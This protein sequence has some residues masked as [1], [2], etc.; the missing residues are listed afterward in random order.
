M[1]AK[2]TDP[3][4]RKP[5]IKRKKR[6]KTTVIPINDHIGPLILFDYHEKEM[7]VKDIAALYNVSPQSVYTYMQRNPWTKKVQVKFYPSD[8][9]N[10]VE[11]DPLKRV[12]LLSND[13]VMNIELTMACIRY[14][15]E[16]EIEATK[17][18]QGDKTATLDM[19]ELI[20]FFEKAAPYVLPKKDGVVKKVESKNI[21]KGKAHEMFKTQMEVKKAN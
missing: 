18:N 21:A 14:K 13:A 9:L 4:K 6:A 20:T 17:D 19:R 11:M 3:P 2:K 12:E 15:L 16:A 1:T 10:R 7:K 5:L 8:V